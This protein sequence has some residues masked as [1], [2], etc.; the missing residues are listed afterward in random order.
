MTNNVKVC[1][2]TVLVSGDISVCSITCV[3]LI[4]AVYRGAIQV[5]Y[6]RI[7]KIEDNN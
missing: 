2:I 7:S 5:F 6:M 4:S 1:T 3:L